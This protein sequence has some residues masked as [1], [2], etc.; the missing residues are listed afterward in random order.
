MRALELVA[1]IGGYEQHSVVK[2]QPSFQRFL[3]QLRHELGKTQ[4][5]RE[6]SSSRLFLLCCVVEAGLYQEP[7]TDQLILHTRQLAELLKKD[8]PR[9]G[10]DLEE[11]VEGIGK[12]LL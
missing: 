5:D 4:K 12:L 6:I 3:R 2:I 10:Q 7:T 1:S 9:Y 8:E 11:V